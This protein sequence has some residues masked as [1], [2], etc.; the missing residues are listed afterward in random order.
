M[1]IKINDQWTSWFTV[2]IYTGYLSKNIVETIQILF[3][4]AWIS[5]SY[6]RVDS[7]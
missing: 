5:V 6:D 7:D 4:R 3:K 1:V 2:R